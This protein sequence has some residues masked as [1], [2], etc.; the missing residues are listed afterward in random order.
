MVA[1]QARAQARRMGPQRKSG[2][3]PYFRQREA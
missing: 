1:H 3:E 2:S